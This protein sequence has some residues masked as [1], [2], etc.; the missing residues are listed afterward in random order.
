ML[1][2]THFTNHGG[3]GTRLQ[4][5]VCLTF[6]VPFKSK[7]LYYLKLGRYNMMLI[8]ISLWDKWDNFKLNGKFS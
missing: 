4:I 7:Q 6:M 3:L 8:S 2:E 5:N 1:R